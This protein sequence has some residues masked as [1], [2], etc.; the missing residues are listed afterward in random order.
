MAK[1]IYLLHHS[2]LIHRDLKPSNVLVNE[3]CEAK[4]CDFGLVRLEEE[5][6]DGEI[7][8]MT[9]YIA[10]RWYR[11]PELLLGSRDYSKEVDMWALGCLIGEMFNGKAM[12]PG[13]STINQI[14]RVL[15]WTGTPS[16]SEM[17]HLSCSS[18]QAMLQL[19]TSKRKANQHDFF[20]SRVPPK[21]LQLI[22]KLLQFDPVK[23]IT[24]EQV[25]KHEYLAEFYNE[26]D[27]KDIKN[28][29]VKIQLHINDNKKASVKDYR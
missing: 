28:M 26:R 21:C 12:F 6:G 5:G 13:N 16:P 7:P 8:I 11:A 9:D 20:S 24:I 15:A 29:K 4:L 17:K 3:S 2:N 25:L 19:L 10:T 22:Q 18:N 1:A 14:E 23:R 27:F